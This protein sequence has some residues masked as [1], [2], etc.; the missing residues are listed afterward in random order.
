MAEH[1]THPG[2]GQQAPLLNE[3]KLAYGSVLELLQG[4]S[5]GKGSGYYQPSF[6]P[7]M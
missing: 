6:V 4:K 2:L 7:F 1:M 5:Q 3:A